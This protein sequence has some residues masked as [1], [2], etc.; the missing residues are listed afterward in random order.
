MAT[1]TRFNEA[2]REQISGNLARFKRRTCTD[3]GTLAAVAMVLTSDESGT[4][5]FLITRRASR[6]RDHAG[7]WALPGG[8]MDPGETSIRTALRELH[9]E[10]DVALDES[11]VLGCL[12]DYATRSGF[13]I[14]P[15]IVWAGPECPTRPNPEEVAEIHRVA[16]DALDA[17]DVPELRRIPESDHPVLSIPLLDTHIHAPTAAVLFQFR[18]VAIHGRE[19]RVAHYEQPVFAW[20]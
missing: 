20:K 6:L 17:P 9:E 15:V 8:R 2:L 10:I 4:A 16:V 14:T 19:T 7:Q 12:D 18:E 13:I 1:Q 11:T 5:S 3:A